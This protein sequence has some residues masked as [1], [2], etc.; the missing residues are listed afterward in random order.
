MRAKPRRCSLKR[1][2]S[3]LQEVVQS[4]VSKALAVVQNEVRRAVRQPV[5]GKASAGDASGPTDG[6][7][8]VADLPRASEIPAAT[9]YPAR[10][11]SESRCRMSSRT[12]R[13]SPNTLRVNIRCG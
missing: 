12:T 2:L 10:C 3:G 11:L 4:P 7:A 1:R 5:N 13:A 6:D 9:A 8:A